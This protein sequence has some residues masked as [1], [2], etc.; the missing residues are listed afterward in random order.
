MGTVFLIMNG[1]DINVTDNIG[2]T[3]L[4]VAIQKNN[5][6]VEIWLNKKGKKKF[7]P[8]KIFSSEINFGIKSNKFFSTNSNKKNFPPKFFF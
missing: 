4:D 2:R 8:P 7:F 1:C 3:A 6:E 5:K